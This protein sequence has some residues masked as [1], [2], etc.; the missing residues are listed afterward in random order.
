MTFHQHLIK[1]DARF[2]VPAAK[3]DQTFKA[4]IA[5]ARARTKKWIP[6]LAANESFDIEYVKG[7]S[8]SAYNWYKGGAR[9]LIQVNVDLPIGIGGEAPGVAT[10]LQAGEF[11]AL[12][13]VRGEQGKLS[14]FGQHQQLVSDGDGGGIVL[15]RAAEAGLRPFHFAR[16]RVHADVVALWSLRV[17]VVLDGNRGGEVDEQIFVRPGLGCFLAC[18]GFGN[19]KADQADGM[20]VHHHTVPEQDGTGGVTFGVGLEGDAPED[21]AIGQIR[22]EQGVG[23]E[24][25]DLAEANTQRRG[26]DSEGQTIGGQGKG[27]RSKANRM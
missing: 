11:F 27:I 26:A 23:G 12:L 4:A 13:R 20:R 21:A 5:E 19:L 1:F 17:E 14:A 18:A 9:S 7:K 24:R 8:W 3:V 22:A 10:H 15:L 25:H 6:K 2:A 16:P